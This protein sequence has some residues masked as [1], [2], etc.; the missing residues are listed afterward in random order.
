MLKKI[1]LILG[2]HYK[3]MVILFFMYI[4]SA[5]VDTFA[6]Y[7]TYPLIYAIIQPD[8]MM[9]NEYVKMLAQYIP[10]TDTGRVIGGI[11]LLVALLYVFRNVFVLIL[12]YVKCIYVKKCQYYVFDD[13]F[14]RVSNRPYY[15][16]S[17]TN[18]SNIQK[19]CIKDINSLIAVIESFLKVGANI[20]SFL[21]LVVL[22]AVMD[23]RLTLT[24]VIIVLLMAVF[25]NMPI[26]RKMKDYGV[27]YGKEYA[28]VMKS[29]Q[30]FVG[31]LKNVLTNKK[32]AFFQEEF[33]VHV[34]NYSQNESKYKFFNVMPGYVMNAVVMTFVFL[35]IGIMAY[36][37]TDVSLQI[38]VW[39]MF[40]MAAIKL[41]PAVSN[42]ISHYNNILYNK[43]S[44]DI[45]YNQMKEDIV[46][47]ERQDVK[48][49]QEQLY[50]RDGIFVKD[51]TFRYADATSNLF[52]N[53]SMEIPINK[54]VAFVGSTGAGKTTLA[55]IIL[56]LHRSDSGS[57]FAGSYDISLH[58]GWWAKQIGYIPQSVYLLEDT[59]RANVALGYKDEDIDD[60]RVWECLR[61][62]QME[63]YVRSMPKQLETVT[64]ENGIKLSGGQRQRI[65]IA[66][67]LYGNPQFIVLDEATSALDSETEKIIMEAINNLAG[68]KTLLIIAHRLSTIEK[69]EIVYRIEDGIVSRER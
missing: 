18:T 51:V 27:I 69:C 61:Q 20:F 7:T 46:F 4:F 45:L 19:I 34:K 32:Q 17:D 40:V 65:G 24:A 38:P 57:V 8:D 9:E 37:G 52:T 63:E 49:E 11:A 50:F 31:I 5:M 33:D 14:K 64:G 30:Q 13:F 16:F 67:A 42:L 39:G 55:D 25:V 47:E 62:A 54:S 56:G 12:E 15:W 28:E 59:V 66:R 68:K 36:S 23:F 6:V 21:F 10:M 22:L 2:I 53:V 41:L 48:E 1:R 58:A 44:I 3:G 43:N 35:Y 29:V 26:T 60:E